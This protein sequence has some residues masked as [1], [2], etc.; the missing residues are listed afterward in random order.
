M[1]SRITDELCLAPR[2]SPQFPLLLFH[3]Y[4]FLHVS[5]RYPVFSLSLKRDQHTD[6][7]HKC[8]HYWQLKRLPVIMFVN[9]I[10]DG[11]ISCDLQECLTPDRTRN[12]WGPL[13][14]HLREH[15]RRQDSRMKELLGSRNLGTNWLPSS[16]GPRQCPATMFADT[17]HRVLCA[18]TS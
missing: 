7:V 11:P 3:Q 12:K 17:R 10:E 18:H 15:H 5:L 2:I 8:R 9:M 6:K 4:F 14:N 13:R 16:S 1:V